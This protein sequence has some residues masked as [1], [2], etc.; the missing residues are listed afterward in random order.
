MKIKTI[1]C[2]GLCG[3]LSIFSSCTQDENPKDSTIFAKTDV[4]SPSEIQQAKEL[5]IPV[6]ELSN[7]SEEVKQ[8]RTAAIILS[9]YV[10]LEGTQY[11]LDISEQDAQELGV[12]PYLYEIIKNEILSTN[13]A[14]QEILENGDSIELCDIQA[15]SKAYKNG[16]LNLSDNPDK[17]SSVAYPSGNITTSGQEDGTASFK[18]EYE[19]TQ[20][21]FRCRTNAALSPIYVCT[22]TSWG[23]KKVG[24]KIG[25]LFTTTEITVPLVASG[26]GIYAGLTFA[27]SDSNGGS[28]FWQAQ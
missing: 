26:S 10:M 5:A 22:V 3:I 28:C 13:A 17:Y 16:E 23:E 6:S 18:T 24:S 11:K 4:F 7:L 1:L 25:T 20:V 27:T 8:K 19:H 15:I 12:T 14:I 9:D 21:L 2:L